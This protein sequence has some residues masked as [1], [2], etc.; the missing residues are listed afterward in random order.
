MKD[1]N[2]L[3]NSS[4]IFFIISLSST[5]ILLGSSVNSLFYLLHSFCLVISSVIPLNNFLN[6]FLICYVILSVDSA[7]WLLISFPLIPHRSDLGIWVSRESFFCLV[8]SCFLPGFF[9]CLFALFFVLCL[10]LQLIIVER[11][12]S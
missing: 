1:F 8:F 2:S 11:L 12:C 5:S 10:D 4:L 9:V 6:Y 7:M 3:L